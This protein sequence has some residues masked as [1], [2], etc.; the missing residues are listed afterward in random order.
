MYLLLLIVYFCNTYSK[1]ISKDV[2]LPVHETAQSSRP[3]LTGRHTENNKSWILNLYTHLA[4]MLCMF[5]ACSLV[6]SSMLSRFECMRI[7]LFSQLLIC[8]YLFNVKKVIFIMLFVCAE[9]EYQPKLKATSA[10]A[11]PLRRKPVF[12]E[13]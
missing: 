2:N 7:I 12:T 1:G 10:S 11:R 6:V 3:L 9:L 8:C 5:A 4:R 13:I